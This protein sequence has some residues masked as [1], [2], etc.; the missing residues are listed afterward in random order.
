MNGFIELDRSFYQLPLDDSSANNSDDIDVEDAIR[1]RG[2]KRLDWEGLLQERKVILLAEAGSGKTEEIRQQALRLESDNKFSFFMRLE[3]IRDR[4]ERGV[5]EVGTLEA[6][7]EWLNSDDEGWL[8]LDSIDESRLRHHSDFQQAIG[9]VSGAIAP[10]LDRVNIVMTGRVNAWKPKTDLDLCNERLGSPILGK[11]KIIEAKNEIVPSPKDTLLHHE[12]RQSERFISGCRNDFKVYSI[13]DLST[14]QKTKFLLGSEIVDASGFLEEIQKQGADSYTTRPQDLEGIIAFWKKNKKVG[15]RFQ[16]MEYNVKRRLSERSKKSEVSHPITDERVLYGAQT[17]AAATTFMHQYNIRVEDGSDNSNGVNV[18]PILLGWNV[19]ESD[20]LLNR[21]MFVP[22][23][24][25][26]V[27]FHHRVVREFLLAEW[28]NS[29]LNKKGSRKKIETL[30]FSKKY[31]VSVITPSMRP[32][33]SWLIIFDEKIREKA[34]SIEPEVVF[35]CGAPSKLP[36]EVRSQALKFV[37]NKMAW[38][39][40]IH[41]VSGIDTIQRF[42]HLDMADDIKELLGE[43]KENFEI[44]S[45]LMDM[46]LQGHI[47]NCLKEAKSF[48]LDELIPNRTRTKAINAVYEIGS[49]EDFQEILDCLFSQK[50]EIDRTLLSGLL[51][52]IDVSSEALDWLFHVL[53]KTA[54]PERYHVDGLSHAFAQFIERIEIDML[55]ELVRRLEGLLS[56]S[57]FIEKRDCRISK[58]YA[59]LMNCGAKAV[60]RLILVRNLEALSESSL[61]ILSRIPNFRDFADYDSGSLNVDVFKLSSEWNDLNYALFWKDVE[62]TRKNHHDKRGERL[63]NFWHAFTCRQY[64][65]FDVSDF[66]SIKEDINNKTFIDDRLVA[67][68]LAFD[69]YRQNNRPAAWRRELHKLAKNEDELKVRLSRLMRPIAQSSENK[70]F[71]RKELKRKRESEK[72]SE[73]NKK[74]HAD[75]KKWLVANT[76]KLQEKNLLVNGLCLNAHQYLLE[77][78]KKVKDD[79]SYWTQGNW[80]DLK[81]DYGDDVARAFRDGVVNSWRNYTPK[82]RSEDGTD[83]GTPIC[84][85]LGLSGL[86]IESRETE[87]WPAGLSYSNVELACRYAF[88]ELNGFPKWFTKLYEKFP[89]R[90]MSFVLKEI[91]WELKTS[92]EKE[93]KHYIINKVS[94]DCPWLWND[95]A[96]KLFDLLQTEETLSVKNLEHLLKIIQASPIVSD[97]DIANLSSKK[98]ENVQ[99][100]NH[101][102][103]WFSLWIGVEPKKS[104]QKLSRRLKRIKDPA[105]ATNFAMLVIVYLMGNRRDN[106]HTRDSYKT[107]DYLFQLCIL[108]H[109]Y[110]KVSDDINRANM[111]AYSPGLRDDAQDARNKMFSILTEI[112]GEET[113]KALIKLSKSSILKNSHWTRHYAKRRAEIDADI[114][115]WTEGEFLKFKKMLDISNPTEEDLVEIKPNFFGLGL[116]LNA[117]WSQRH[118]FKSK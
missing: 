87:S 60:E 44:S 85:I 50:K 27:R 18:R 81:G 23:A 107:P 118:K 3:N 59:W 37:C 52:L 33:L 92:K 113:Y 49:K 76:N 24:F 20:G 73:K 45:F 63:I 90:V 9:T 114:P 78:M 21:P 56:Q 66:D 61:S 88:W 40:S 105:S 101:L 69:L 5:F 103:L 80:E 19:N 72:R 68:S 39:S 117:L 74:H 38:D 11:S 13:A 94:W 4:I 28:L 64:W 99:C 46:V 42:V 10:A 8:F 115:V 16:L 65:H 25:G 96:P 53:T 79:S 29:F 2:G 36:Y 112:E 108:M 83:G 15:T 51:G 12:S 84:I 31:G 26:T 89:D 54:L 55:V 98:C 30:L 71:K 34:C 57:P 75:W 43:Y 70:K 77:R 67:L 58:K 32:V 35:E 91:T 116:N 22:S 41:S 7:N 109:R 62:E 106:S 100:L 93:E 1:V 110:I 104:I 95:L 111:G 47:K 97:Q 6:F 102:S 48:A 14:E 82:I 17:L 86:E